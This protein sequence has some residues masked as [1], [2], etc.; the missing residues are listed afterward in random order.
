M[1]HIRALREYLNLHNKTN[2]FTR[3]K[4]I[5]VYLLVVFTTLMMI[6]KAIE[7]CWE[8]MF[9]ETCFIVYIYWFYYVSLNI[10]SY[11]YVFVS[12]VVFS[13]VF[14]FAGCSYFVFL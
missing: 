8:L 2:K 9:D 10:L 1:F 3:R 11:I 4:F 7:T 12:Q 6:A 14:S 13:V 5:H